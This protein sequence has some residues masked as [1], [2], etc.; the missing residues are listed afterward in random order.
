MLAEPFIYMFLSLHSLNTLIIWSGISAET[1]L[2]LVGSVPLLIFMLVYFR[3]IF[4]YFIRNFERQADLFSF[5]TM[6]NSTA[7]GF[8]L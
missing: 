3:F 5:A 4:G 7:A 1:A 2:T 8:G 6:G